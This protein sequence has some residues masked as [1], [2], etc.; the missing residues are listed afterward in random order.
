MWP[1]VQE[2]LTTRDLRNTCLSAEG[3]QCCNINNILCG[4]PRARPSLHAVSDK[5]NCILSCPKTSQ[6]WL[7]SVGLLKTSRY[8]SR[9]LID[10]TR[11]QTSNSEIRDES[12]ITEINTK[13]VPTALLRRNSTSAWT[14][15]QSFPPES[16]SQADHPTSTS[17]Y[18]SINIILNLKE[19]FL[20]SIVR[21]LSTL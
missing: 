21:I 12:C 16:L 2:R 3:C 7:M 10:F 9:P 18:H 4:T 17:E 1:H 5:N 8:L 14:S 11:R 15:Y 13:R 20:I 6:H 19:F